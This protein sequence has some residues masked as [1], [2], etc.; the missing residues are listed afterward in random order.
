ME[1]AA[2]VVQIAYN[3]GTGLLFLALKPKENPYRAPDLFGI[4]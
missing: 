4:T 2:I 3:C 1:R